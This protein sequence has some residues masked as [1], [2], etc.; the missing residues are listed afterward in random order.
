LIA[1]EKRRIVRVLPRRTS[2]SRPDPRNPNLERVIAANIDI[3]ANVVSLRQPPLRTGLIDRYLIAIERS[4][5]EPLVCVNKVDLLESASDLDALQPYAQMGVPVVLCS[6]AT[7]AGLP[8]LT[9][10]LRDK[11]CVFS[12]HSGVGKTSLL[13]ALDPDLHLTTGDL[14]TATHTGRH[15][16]TFSSL[17]RLPS[18]AT[19]IDTPGIREF[20]LWSIQPADVRR[21]FRDLAQ[22]AVSCAF[23]NCTHSHEQDCGVK[24]ALADGLIP[25]ARYSAYRRIVDSL[26]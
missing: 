1:L 2:L 19:I 16:T 14:S 24:Q 23:S 11:V 12:G 21:Y 25:P 9:N 5:A 17:H 10:A 3:I 26:V 7:G 15:T 18:G 13:N 20:G 8:E 6:A 22:Y 4:G